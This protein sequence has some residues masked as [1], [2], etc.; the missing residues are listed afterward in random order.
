M[1]NANNR[2]DNATDPVFYIED[3]HGWV[4]FCSVDRFEGP[5]WQPSLSTWDHL[6]SIIENEPTRFTGCRIVDSNA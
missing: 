6:N 3:Q 1:N 2:P 5:R 4:Y